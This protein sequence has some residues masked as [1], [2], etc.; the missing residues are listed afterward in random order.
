MIWSHLDGGF[1]V[2]HN[3]IRS[4]VSFVEQ[5]AFKALWLGFLM[6]VATPGVFAQPHDPPLSPSQRI[7][8][9]IRQLGSSQFAA[10][11][12]AEAELAELG[13]AALD[14]LNQA[15]FDD[16][17]E[18]AIRASRLIRS[19]QVTWTSSEDPKQVR[20]L[21][22]GY[23]KLPYSDR[24]RAIDNLA[25]VPSGGALPAI[26]RLARYEPSPQ[27]SKYAAL[28]F[29]TVPPPSDKTRSTIRPLIERTIGTSERDSAQWIRVGLQLWEDPRAAPKAWARIVDKEESTFAVQPGQT[30]RGILRQL[31]M[32]YVDVLETADHF[33]EAKQ[34]AR[35][36]LPLVTDERGQL[37]EISDWIL[38]H[39]WWDVMEAFHRRFDDG[40]RQ[41][42]A[43][44]FRLADAR[45]Q[46]GDAEGAKEVAEAA[47]SDISKNGAKAVWLMGMSLQND[48]FFHWSEQAYRKLVDAPEP[49]WNEI[50]AV[51]VSLAELLHDLKRDHEAAQTLEKLVIAG[52]DPKHRQVI[53]RDCRQSISAL[54][55][56][57]AFFQAMHFGRI[58]ERA[59]QQKSLK[60]ALEKAPFNADTLIAQYRLSEGDTEQLAEARDRIAKAT[61]HYRNSISNAKKQVSEARTRLDKDQARLGLAQ[62]CNQVAWLIANT[63]GDRGWAIEC[64]KESL[65]IHPD[66]GGFHDTLARCYFAVGNLDRAILEQKKALTQDPFS[67]SFISQ[68]ELFEAAKRK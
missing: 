40:F 37:L 4:M 11:E 44:L 6:L 50:A 33:D 19:I 57:G 66:S 55:A 35:R 5:A 47:L 22:T 49:V 39:R 7:E 2:L 29:L 36:V 51:H 48:G 17:V 54:A 62:D 61:Q 23:G 13:L 10:R 30:S 67:P 46:A 58:G 9:M 32:Q 45:R 59:S 21:L 31:L 8:K 56:R 34:I 14:A 65:L 28:V 26:S 3:S 1:S 41:N 20:Q 63:E 12:R 53:E 38:A 27:M 52:E 42:T 25:L 16:D 18:I 64:S 43:L 60:A 24:R 68:M 15:Q